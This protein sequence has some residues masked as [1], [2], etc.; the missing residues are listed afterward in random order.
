MGGKTATVQIMAERPDGTFTIEDCE[1]VS[2]DVSPALDVDDPMSTAY[3]LEVSS[4]GI[5]RPLVRAVDFQRAVGHVAKIELSRALDLGDLS[6]QLGV[7]RRRYRGTIEAA[8]DEAV[9]L[10]VEG[11][12]EPVTVALP[13]ESVEDANLVLTDELLAA[14]QAEQAEKAKMNNPGSANDNAALVEDETR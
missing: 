11:S 9:E 12:S 2:R 5:D 10:A 13:Y 6:D 8:S 3:H 1:A 7:G 14:A 4:P